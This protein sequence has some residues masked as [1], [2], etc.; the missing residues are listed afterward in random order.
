MCEW[1]EFHFHP[2][3]EANLLILNGGRVGG[4]TFWLLAN[5]VTWRF[6]VANL[7]N[8]AMVATAALPR[9]AE[10]LTTC[11]ETNTAECSVLLRSLVLTNRDCLSVIQLNQHWTNLGI[12]FGDCSRFSSHL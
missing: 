6:Y 8:F 4:R 11:T 2:H 12:R 10:R 5:S 7:A 3:E 1:R 9:F